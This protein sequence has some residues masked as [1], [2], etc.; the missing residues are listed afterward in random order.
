[1]LFI[2]DV[3]RALIIQTDFNVYSAPVVT[4]QPMKSYVA[5][6]QLNIG[7][8]KRM[9]KSRKREPQKSQCI[10]RVLDMKKQNW[11]FTAA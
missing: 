11:D 1:M 8:G 10:K 5:E 9:R 4:L 3:F 7:G 2:G 6:T